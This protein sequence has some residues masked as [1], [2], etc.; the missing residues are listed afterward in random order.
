MSALEGYYES[1]LQDLQLIIQRVANRQ[2]LDI[3]PQ[4][5]AC[6]KSFPCHGHNGIIVI[7]K[8]GTKESIS[9]PSISI[10][11]TMWYYNIDNSHFRSYIDGNFRQYL[12]NGVRGRL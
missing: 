5:N 11:A 6:I 3:L 12:M 4:S 8:N 2:V 7:Y 9:C 10:G 1:V